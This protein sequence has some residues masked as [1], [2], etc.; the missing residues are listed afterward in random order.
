MLLALAVVVAL[1][2]G[3]AGPAPARA[4]DVLRHGPRHAKLIALTFDDGWGSANCR[5][6]MN[7]LVRT[8]TAATFFPNA[9]F[10]RYNPGLWR[11]IAAYG[12]PIGN[13]TTGHPFMT[14]LDE[15]AQR[16]QIE[17]D[18]RIVERVLGIEMLKVLRPPYGMFNA[19]TIRAAHAAGY[20]L[21]V[22]WDTSF[23]DTS[24]TPDGRF[25]AMSTYLKRAVRG[26]SGSVI[27]GHCGSLVDPTI[28]PAVIAHYRARGY[29]FVTIPSC[30]GCRTRAR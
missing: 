25:R 9:P 4:A 30:S 2:A 16:R 3:S 21:V 19:A 6:V 1:V 14:R 10:V 27:L 24:R 8:K 22:N 11:E 29:T 23:A 26:Q 17:S 18:E 7:I 5:A 12:F 20:S 13:H 28:L 15:A